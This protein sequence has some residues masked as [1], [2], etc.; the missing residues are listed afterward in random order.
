V[1]GVWVG[2]IGCMDGNSVGAADG[3]PVGDCVGVL[4]GASE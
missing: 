3:F 1:V 2:E 4:V